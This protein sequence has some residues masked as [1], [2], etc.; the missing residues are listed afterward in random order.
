M[1]GTTLSDRAAASN[2]D[3]KTDAAG[4]SGLNMIAARLS[5]G[6]ISESSSSHLLPNEASK[7]AKPLISARPGE[8]RDQTAAD[9]IDH[10]PKDDR[11]RPRLPLDGSGRPG[12]VC[13]DDV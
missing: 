12:R 9:G 6:A 5:P 13:R 1:I 10:A 8:P 7:P 4:K 2:E 3:I 11:D